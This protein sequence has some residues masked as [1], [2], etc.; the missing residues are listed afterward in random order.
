MKLWINR[1]KEIEFDAAEGHT[2]R[3]LL[4]QAEIYVDAPCGGRENCGKCVVRFYAG[5]P[6]PLPV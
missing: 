6:E 2:L 1:T 4:E 3:E 5:A